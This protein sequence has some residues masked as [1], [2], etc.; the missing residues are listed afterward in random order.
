MHGIGAKRKRGCRIETRRVRR[1]RADRGSAISVDQLDRRT[2]N[3]SA[4]R[5]CNR[6]ADATLLLRPG[7]HATNA[8]KHC[9]Y[10]DPCRTVQKTLSHVHFSS[11]LKFSAITYLVHLP[12]SSAII[13]TGAIHNAALS[14]LNQDRRLHSKNPA[15]SMHTVDQ[16]LVYLVQMVQMCRRVM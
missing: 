13:S 6:A 2:L 1:Q 9:Q 8:G 14:R 11:L 7:S 3:S 4:A 12:D 5:V 15:V 16:E 10:C